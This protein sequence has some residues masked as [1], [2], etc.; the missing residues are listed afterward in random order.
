MCF[1]TI[2]RCVL[3]L[4]T[5][6][7]FN[8]IPVC[9]PT[10]YRCVFQPYNGVF[11][12]YIPVCFSTIYRCLLQLYTGVFFN[13]PMHHF[14]NQHF[15]FHHIQYMLLPKPITRKCKCFKLIFLDLHFSNFF[16]LKYIALPNQNPTWVAKCWSIK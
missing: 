12:N 13:Y 16:F 8:Y 9:F 3:Q 5:G 10:I 15:D 11:F 2:Y 4:N 6:V 7:F 1:P 14:F